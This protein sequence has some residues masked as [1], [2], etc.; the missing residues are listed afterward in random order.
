MRNGRAIE[1]ILDL[2]VGLEIAYGKMKLKQ[3]RYFRVFS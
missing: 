3:R 1:V 2:S